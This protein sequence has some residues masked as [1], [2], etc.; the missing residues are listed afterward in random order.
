MKEWA[1]YLV[2]TTAEFF[3]FSLVWIA[4]SLKWVGMKLW[5]KMKKK[6]K[7]K[8]STADE[9][10]KLQMDAFKKRPEYV[11][12]LTKVEA[13]MAK[14]SAE[15]KVLFEE[16]QRLLQMINLADGGLGKPMNASKQGG[17]NNNN[18][19]NNKQKGN[20]GG[21]NNNNGGNKQPAIQNF[22]PSLS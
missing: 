19:N 11:K 6:E 10:A 13:D 18:Q 4:K 22:Q 5:A 1:L 7:P 21:N 9:S 17:N 14:H 12:Q 8:F 16:Q 2:K 15:F 20:N 3:W